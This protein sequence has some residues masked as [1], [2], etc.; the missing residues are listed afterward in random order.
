MVLITHNH[1][2]FVNAVVFAF[3]QVNELLTLAGLMW[4]ELSS[5]GLS[6]AVLFFFFHFEL[7]S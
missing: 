5:S 3:L 1:S 7:N 4:L 6:V 2:S